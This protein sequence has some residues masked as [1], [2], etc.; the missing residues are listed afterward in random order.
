MKVKVT[1]QAR[2]QLRQKS[3]YIR[4]TF[5]LRPSS[6]FVQKVRRAYKL[7]VSNPF[8]GPVE[9]L[10]ADR[11]VQ[12]RSIVINRLNKMVYYINDDVIEIVAFWDT[13]RE[14]KQQAD[15]IE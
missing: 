2:A 3:N 10:M 9:P 11:P 5:G 12:Y 13:R 1:K 8:L 7:L 15:Q 14:P 6:E 4:Y